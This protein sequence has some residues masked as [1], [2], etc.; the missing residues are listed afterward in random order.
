[1]TAGCSFVFVSSDYV[2]DG[3]KGQYV[4]TDSPSPVNVYGATKLEA[5]ELVR[6]MCEDHLILRPALFGFS[7]L[8]RPRSVLDRA[9]RALARAEPTAL[10]ADQ[11]FSPVSTLF[12][13]AAISAATM[14][15]MV[16]TF[17]AGCDERI[18]KYE[19]GRK[20]LAAAGRADADL[21]RPSH[22]LSE[23]RRARRP[24]DTSLANAKIKEALQLREV[25]VDA[26]IREVLSSEEVRDY[27]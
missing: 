9:L 11:F 1:M 3:R 5:E 26:L 24:Q 21:L 16:G 13:A 20:V 2:F 19:F 14:G 23:A 10:A 22:A 27:L 18:T 25:R 15:G 8:E 4:E 17:H 12:L 7:S 6:D